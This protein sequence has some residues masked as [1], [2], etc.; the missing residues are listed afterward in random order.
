M[1]K[2]ISAIAVIAAI[3]STAFSPAHA[4]DGVINFIGKLETQTC[5]IDVNGVA[6][7]AVYTVV[8]PTVSI[9]RL[10]TAGATT[11]Q[12]GFVIGLKNCSSIV[13]NGVTAFFESSPLVNVITGNL[14]STGTAHHV[15]LQLVDGASGR[16]IRVGDMEQNA[17]TTRIRMDAT[18]SALLPYAVQYYVP[19]PAATAGTVAS[20]VTYSIVYH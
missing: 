7:P 11:G 17:V 6:N 15:E 4:G 5:T 9:D 10:A 12:S 1:K 20:N 2:T 3:G 18:G 16:P 8:L 19:G 13:D 14:L